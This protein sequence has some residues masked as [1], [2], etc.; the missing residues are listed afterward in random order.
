MPVNITAISFPPSH[1]H[2]IMRNGAFY[3][4]I[5]TKIH[6]PSYRSL[7]NFIQYNNRYAYEGGNPELHPEQIHNVEINGIYRWLSLSIGYKYYK[8]V[9]FWTHKL[10]NNQAISFSSTYNYDHSENLYAKYLG[11]P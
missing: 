9:M 3:S 6:R 1:Y 7:R 2:G 5:A 11:F 8:D 10:Y 4:I